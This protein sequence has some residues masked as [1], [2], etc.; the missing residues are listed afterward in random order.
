MQAMSK[1]TAHFAQAAR[2][3][4]E[5]G[6]SVLALFMMILAFASS[7]L[8]QDKDENSKP[9]SHRSDSIAAL[10][11]LD[12]HDLTWQKAQ[13]EWL[14]QKSTDV[15]KDL[16]AHGIQQVTVYNRVKSPESAEEKALRKGIS[17]HELNDLFGMR[18]VVSNELDVYRCLNR[19]CE[20]YKI[21]P[22][23][24]KNYIIAP[25][26]SGYQSVHV[27]T[28]IDDMHRIEFQI[29]TET[30]HAM[31]EAEHEVYKARMRAA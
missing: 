21:I 30:M 12:T 4:Y 23:S 15:T 8:L 11:A 25:K 2:H 20:Q 1:T 24:L 19:I 3:F 31:A 17:V 18:I 5:R 7:G 29:R 10:P 13:T 6:F 22:G 27:V 14:S 9:D 28:Q 26:A 16:K